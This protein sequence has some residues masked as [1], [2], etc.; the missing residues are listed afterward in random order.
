MGKFHLSKTFQNASK[1][2]SSY[3]YL[4]IQFLLELLQQDQSVMH[5]FIF[6]V[7]LLLFF[8]LWLW[9]LRTE[10]EG[11]RELQYLEVLHLVPLD[12]SKGNYTTRRD[13]C[14]MKMDEHHGKL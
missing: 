11:M 12:F 3:L 9:L 4:F 14:D 6:F 5:R 7:F 10:L 2:Y 13:W 8:L 1:N